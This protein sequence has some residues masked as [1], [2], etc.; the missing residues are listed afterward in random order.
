MNIPFVEG[1]LGEKDAA[2]RAIHGGSLPVDG[3]TRRNQTIQAQFYQA[4]LPALLVHHEIRLALRTTH[5]HGIS[6]THLLVKGI[7][8]GEVRNIF[9]HKLRRLNRH[10]IYFRAGFF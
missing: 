1:A 10:Y 5:E 4:A 3:K 6:A 9:S 7:V 8:V 2:I